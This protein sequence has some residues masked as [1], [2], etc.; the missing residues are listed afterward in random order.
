[1]LKSSTSHKWYLLL[2]FNFLFYQNKNRNALLFIRHQYHRSCHQCTSTMI[3]HMETGRRCKRLLHNLF[4][5]AFRNCS[6][7]ESNSGFLS[8][9]PPS[10]L[11]KAKANANKFSHSLRR[12]SPVYKSDPKDF[13]WGTPPTC[14]RMGHFLKDVIKAGLLE[15]VQ[16]ITEHYFVLVK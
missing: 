4:I 7:D 12:K 8:R 6:C 3:V 14:M 2:I 10:L 11:F 5:N 15:K 1:M 16:V 13:L 9:S